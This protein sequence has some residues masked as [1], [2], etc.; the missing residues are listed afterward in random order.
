LVSA[1][2]AVADVAHAEKANPAVRSNSFFVISP[3]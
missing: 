3:P 2:A 1:V